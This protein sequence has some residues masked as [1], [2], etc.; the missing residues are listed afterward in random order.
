MPAPVC[1]SERVVIYR[2]SEF[3]EVFKWPFCQ[4]VKLQCCNNVILRDISSRLPFRAY[5]DL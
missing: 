1:L 3:D 4:I 5:G 2:G